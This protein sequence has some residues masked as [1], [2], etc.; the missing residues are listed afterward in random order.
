MNP[1]LAQAWK[2]ALDE[3]PLVAILRGLTPAEADAVGDALWNANWRVFEVP[4][5]SPQPLESIARLAR[6]FPGAVVGAGTVRTEDEVRAVHAAGGR[7]VVS[8][9]F[10]ARV[11]RAASW[12]GMVCVPGVMTPTEAFAALEAGAAALKLFPAEMIPPAA[13][14]ALRAVLPAAVPLLPVGGIAPATMASYLAA[15]AD[16]FG[17]GSALYKPGT[18]PEEVSRMARAFADAW[19]GTV[20]A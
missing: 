17:I 14:K 15:G 19:A 4:L 13:V 18:A 8:P 6:R 12:S 3:L 16:G 20:R 5:N 11:V 9:H 10:D 7:L 1:L 2:R